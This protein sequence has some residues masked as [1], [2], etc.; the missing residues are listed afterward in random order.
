VTEAPPFPAAGER[1][2]LFLDI[3]GTLLELA[4]T[5]EAV[6]VDAGLR[7][8]LRRLAQATGGALALVSGRALDTIDALFQPLL[9][10]AAG[11]HGLERRR[12]D[13]TLVLIPAPSAALASLRPKLAAFAAPRPGVLLED[14]GQSLALHYRLAPELG[15]AVRRRARQFAAEAGGAL[16]L[17]EGNMVVEFQPP[18]TDKGKAIAAFLAEPPFQGRRPVFLGDDTTDEDGFRAIAARDGIAVKIGAAPRDF[19]TAARYAMSDVTVARRWLESVADVLGGGAEEHP[20]HPP[21]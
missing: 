12:A 17:I 4:P 21:R 1:W 11:L 14:K 13:G 2:A 18:G 8:L 3:D 16:R 7:L 15:S 20:G 10:P 6:L 9:L 5:P 19:V